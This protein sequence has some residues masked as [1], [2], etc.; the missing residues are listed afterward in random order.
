MDKVF[1]VRLTDDNF[2]TWTVADNNYSITTH[3]YIDDCGSI[4]K[5]CLTYADKASAIAA[6]QLYLDKTKP[7]TKSNGTIRTFEGGATR[8]TEQNK[9]DYEA[10][11]SPLVDKC[12]ATYLNKHRTQS[13]GSLRDGDNWQKLFG[14]KHTDVCMKSLCRHVVDVRLAHRG[15]ASEQPIVDSLCGIIFNAKAYLLKLML[16]EENYEAAISHETGTESTPGYGGNIN[17]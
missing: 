4:V 13:D 16:N 14:E 1:R 8:D 7:E 3:N 15:H 9:L 5:H 12:Y 11:N 6:L 17:E 2:S 10:F